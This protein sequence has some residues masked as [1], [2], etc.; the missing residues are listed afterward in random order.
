MMPQIQTKLK[1]SKDK[2]ES[3]LERYSRPVINSINE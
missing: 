3:I 1:K 2:T